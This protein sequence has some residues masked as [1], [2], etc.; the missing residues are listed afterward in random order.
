M[1]K[2]EMGRPSI[3]WLSSMIKRIFPLSLDEV[4]PKNEARK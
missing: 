1:L 2:L 3:R 4:E